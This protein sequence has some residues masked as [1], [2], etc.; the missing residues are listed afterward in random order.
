[1]R[2]LGLD[3]GIASIGWA[4][5]ETGDGWGEII[6]AGTRMFD[7]PETDKERTPTNQL[8]RL[9][10]GQRRVIRRRRHRMRDIRALFGRHGLLTETGGNALKRPGLDPWVLRVAALDRRLEPLE[11]AVALGN[12]ARHRGFRSNSKRDRGANAPDDSRKMLKAIAASQD[13]LAEWRSVAEMMVRDASF[14]DRKRNRSGEFSRTIQRDDLECEVRTIFE[15]Q[16]RL[17]STFASG[18]FEEDFT[19]L[20]FSQLPLQDSEHLVG[21]CPFEPGEKRTARR[22]YSFELFRLLSRLANLTLLSG[23]QEERLSAEQIGSVSANFGAQKT[24]TFKSVR[25]LLDLDPRTRFEGVPIEREGDDVVARSGTTAEGTATLRSILGTAWGSLLHQPGKLDRIAEVITFRDDPVSI[26][27]GLELVGLEPVIVEALMHG[28]T[29]GAFGKFNGAGHISAK[30]ARALLPH[31]ARGLVYSDACKEVGYDHAARLEVSIAD[32]RNPVAR[33]AL[34]E[35]LKQVRAIALAYKDKPIDLIHVE[36][37]RDLGKGADEREKLRRGIEDRTAEK[38]RRRGEFAELLHHAPSDEEL[39]RFELWKEQNC[40]CLYSDELIPPQALAAT[41]NSVQ[42]DHILPWS[43]FGDD[44]FRNKTLCLASANQRKKGRTPFEWFSGD[45]PDEWALFTARVEAC[46]SMKGGKKGGHYLRRN[47]AEVEERFKSR[48]LGDTRYATRLLLD[49]LARRFPKDGTVPVR[50]RPGALTS[51]LRRA[52]GLEDIKK[53]AD[54]RRREDDRH[55]ALD[56]LV[57]A[58]TT[59]AA[60]NDLTRAFQ[61]AEQ[62]GRSRSLTHAIPEPWPG[63][64]DAARA[65]VEKVFV[66]RAERRRARGEAHAATIRQVKERDGK[67]IVYERKAVEALKPADLARIKD[68]DRNAALHD[69]LAAWLAA[70][71]PKSSPPRSPK[72]DVIRKVRLATDGKVAVEVRDGT[73]DRGEMVRVDVFREPGEGKRRDRFHLVPIYPHQVADRQGWPK[74]PDRAVVA[75]KPE[76]EWTPVDA[77]EFRFSLS[78]NHLVEA[79]KP[80]GEVIQGYFK[81]LDRS[82]GAVIVAA[83]ESSRQVIRGIGAKTLL[84]FRKFT[85]DRLG[86]AYPVERET[87]TWHGEVCI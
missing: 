30:A 27:A 34:G 28:V 74:P 75:Y 83:P 57:V 81:G 87:R 47:A 56:A 9:H 68:L 53:D 16:R 85:V 10:R 4:L 15:M 37:A 46:K 14:E 19:A 67:M 44:S 50:A 51:K 1:M 23:G 70:E 48:N 18:E 49:L 63:F 25:K 66:S 35:M 45:K 32:V 72:G 6:G 60:L 41:D 17:G 43:R 59:Q 36:L 86:G 12:I 7:A 61:D 76:S 82:T 3:G 62:H 80:D 54:G 20:A 13:R 71:K 69:A 38:E 79:T 5:I 29:D 73:A 84:D 78:Q 31:L 24:I 77:F 11:L 26:R 21:P 39:L 42:V 65:A 55:H 64:R 52:W 58:A 22:A 33:K 2:I 8:R 40:R